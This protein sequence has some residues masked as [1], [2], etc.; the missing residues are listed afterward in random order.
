MECYLNQAIPGYVLLGLNTSSPCFQNTSS[1][2]LVARDDDDAKNEN[3]QGGALAVACP[4][5]NYFSC[6]GL[7]MDLQFNFSLSHIS[8]LAYQRGQNGNVTSTNSVD[9]PTSL[10]KR[11]QD[12]VKSKDWRYVETPI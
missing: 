6:S 10:P 12:S 8:T 5:V 1:A 11:C 9:M 3:V 2:P 7:Y 4:A